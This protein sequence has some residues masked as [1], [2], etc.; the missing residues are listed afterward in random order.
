M[1]SDLVLVTGAV[2]NAS[3]S[4]ESNL[5]LEDQIAHSN[6]MPAVSRVSEKVEVF[7]SP[8]RNL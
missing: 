2:K 5:R 7:D 1:D 6:A 3:K 8:L 4:G